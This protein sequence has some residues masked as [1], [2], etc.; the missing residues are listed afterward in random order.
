MF[1]FV[2]NGMNRQRESSK[3]NPNSYKLQIDWQLEIIRVLD[4]Y[5][6]MSSAI[7]SVYSGVYKILVI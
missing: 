4:K 7:C 1:A 5:K 6:Y 2:V 3:K